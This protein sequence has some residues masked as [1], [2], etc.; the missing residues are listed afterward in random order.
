MILELE[1]VSWSAPDFDLLV[2]ATLEGPVTGLFGPSGAGKTTVLDLIAGLRNPRS[3]AIRMDGTTLVGNGGRVVPPRLRRIGYV[4]QDR[5]L[6]PHLSVR[7]NIE[8]GRPSGDAGGVF[9]L[10]HV[11]Q[12]LQ[13]GPLLSRRPGN[14]S[15]G[16]QQ[17]V[18][19][20]RALIAGPRLL[21]LDEPLAGLDDALKARALSLLRRVWREFEVPIVYVSHSAEEVSA[22]CD[23]VLVLERGR[24][25]AEGRPADVFEET[26]EVRLRVRKNSPATNERV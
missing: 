3:G 13:I 11:T 19:V 22:L 10:D 5:A 4:P 9:G 25:E 15:G 17:R 23:R 12:V 21:L 2:N 6:F 7:E 24:L 14:L 16:E 18:A 8:Y 20:A 1:Q 26:H